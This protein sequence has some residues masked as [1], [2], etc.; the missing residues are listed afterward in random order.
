MSDEVK[1][2]NC[3]ACSDEQVGRQMS[4]LAHT[5][6]LFRGREYASVEGFY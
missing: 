6:F 4:T 1:P 2:L 3:A 5:S